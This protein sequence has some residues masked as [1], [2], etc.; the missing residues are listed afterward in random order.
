MQDG[1]PAHSAADTL[2]E[3]AERGIRVLKWPP[4][5]PDLNPIEMVWNWM[6]DYIQERYEDSLTK[7]PALR[8][9]VQEAW[10]AVPIEY[11]TELLQSMPARCR[12]VVEAEGGFTR[13]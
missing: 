1:A 3:L 13:F 4:Y 7:Y 5:S 6:K 2:A 11:L 9:A 12:A 10:D 8:Q